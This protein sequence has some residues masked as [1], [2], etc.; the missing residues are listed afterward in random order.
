MADLSKYLPLSQRPV[1][2]ESRVSSDWGPQIAATLLATADLLDGLSPE[3]WEA[4]SLCADWRV[5]DVAGH[6]VWRL[7]SSNRE[8]LRSAG[9]AWLAGRFLNP[10]RAIDAVSRAAAL[11]EPSEL[12]ASLRRIAADRTA[13]IGRQGVTEL[14]E[15]VVHGFD[16]A[17]PLGLAL[18]VDPTAAGAVALGRAQRASTPVKAVLRRRTLVASD[19]LWRV[20]R[21]P[22]YRSTAEDIVLFLFGRAGLTPAPPAAPTVPEDLTDPV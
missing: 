22:D 7:G 14:T 6:L 21:G 1:G 5:R 3:Q 19:A 20:G 17:H 2:D 18:T 11:T 9:R 15:A 13:G 4:P 16:L 12:I 10:N 8:L